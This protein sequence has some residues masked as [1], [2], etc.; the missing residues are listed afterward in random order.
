MR[1]RYMHRDSGWRVLG[2][3]SALCHDL[4]QAR[5]VETIMDSAMANFRL[6]GYLCI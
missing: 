1:L 4:L 5:V 6:H 2:M 3:G